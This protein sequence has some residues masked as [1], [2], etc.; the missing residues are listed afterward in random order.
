MY[1]IKL[2]YDTGDSFHNEYGLEET[3]GVSWSTLELAEEN[4]NRIKEHYEFVKADEIYRW[5]LTNKEI[6]KKKEEAK[7]QRWYRNEYDYPEGSVILILDNGEE[8]VQSA[9]FYCGYF[10]SLTCAEI[11]QDLPKIEFK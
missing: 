1:R 4:L 2:T 6:R 11:I 9:S 7:N 8:F 5:D 10:E 3:L